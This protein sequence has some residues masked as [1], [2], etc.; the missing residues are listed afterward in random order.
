MIMMT[1]QVCLSQIK[2]SVCVTY[3]I[4]MSKLVFKTNNI[5]LKNSSKDLLVRSFGEE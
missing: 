3:F 2:F 4:N 1:F 5:I